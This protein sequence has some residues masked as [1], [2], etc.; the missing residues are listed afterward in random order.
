MYIIPNI[1]I[2]IYYT[3]SHPQLE[4]TTIDV[5][6]YIII[7]HILYTYFMYIIYMAP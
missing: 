4:A 3:P 1:F 6:L 5:G 7:M 2:Y